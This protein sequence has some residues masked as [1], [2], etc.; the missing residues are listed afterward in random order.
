[1]HNSSTE[2]TGCVQ[3]GMQR[4]RI[5]A[6]IKANLLICLRYYG[7]GPYAFDISEVADRVWETVSIFLTP[8]ARVVIKEDRRFPALT[9]AVLEYIQKRHKGE[10]IDLRELI[11]ESAA[12]P[13]E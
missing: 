7:I 1:M 13:V 6:Q 2:S 9:R 11:K 8:K 3:F 4:A 5:Q 12:I 10:V